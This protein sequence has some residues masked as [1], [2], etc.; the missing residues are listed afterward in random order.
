MVGHAG[1][2]HDSHRAGRTAPGRPAGFGPVIGAIVVRARRAHH[3]EPAHA[4]TVG[5]RLSTRLGWVLPL[6]V[7]ASAT[8]LAGV[9]LAHLLGGP[10]VSLAEGWSLI[11][12]AGGPVPFFVTMLVAGPLSEEPGWRGTA[13]P[14]TR[15]SLGRLQAGLR[16]GAVWA[17]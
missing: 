11:S 4:H 2:R 8:V 7:M 13:Y 3:R 14:R 10:V 17:V 9:V 12:D 16:L 1:C 6:L 15:A 5:L